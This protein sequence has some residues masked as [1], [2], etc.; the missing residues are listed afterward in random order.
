MTATRL[1]MAALGLVALAGCVYVPLGTLS[2]VPTEA[3]ATAGNLAV[4]VKP[5]LAAGG[6]TVQAPNPSIVEPY[7]PTDV[8]HVVVQLYK[9]S[10]GTEVALVDAKGLP[11]LYDLSA[12]SFS[13]PLTFSGLSPNT[14]YRFKAFAFKATGLA[15]ADKISVDASSSLEVALT[16]DETP[17]VRSVPVQLM[18]KPFDGRVSPGLD[19]ASGSLTTED[20]AI[21]WEDLR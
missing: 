15:E 21:L 16:N 13:A 6:Y 9:V 8:N 5:Q 3:L 2:K 18:D 17:G 20:E 1:G 19:I 12:A 4:T 10:N 14:T 11:K 7:K